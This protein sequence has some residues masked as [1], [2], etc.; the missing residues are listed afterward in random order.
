MAFQVIDSLDGDT[1]RGDYA[2]P[3]P[4]VVRPLLEWTTEHIAAE[5]RDLLAMSVNS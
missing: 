5:Q 1:V 2:G 3:F 4:G